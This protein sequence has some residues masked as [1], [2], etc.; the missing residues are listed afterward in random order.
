MNKFIAILLL[1]IA[2][3]ALGDYLNCHCKVVK[4]VDGNPD[5]LGLQ[6]GALRKEHPHFNF[7]GGCCGSDMRHVKRIL[8]EAKAA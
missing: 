5:E 8:E 4:V 6:V 2:D 7:L 1:I 3:S